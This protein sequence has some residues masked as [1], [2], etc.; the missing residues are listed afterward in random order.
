M[1]VGVSHIAYALLHIL[2]V[3]EP[4]FIWKKSGP[5]LF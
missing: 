5:S 2:K 3:L 1:V 4:R